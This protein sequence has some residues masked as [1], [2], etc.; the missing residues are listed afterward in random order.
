MLIDSHLH[1]VR[2]KG[3]PRN[4]PDPARA[5]YATFATPEELIHMMD[6]TGVDRGVL[7][8]EVNPE[9]SV[10]LSTV[11]EI[12]DICERYPDRFIPFCNIDPRAGSN[13]P[14]ADLSHPIR[15]YKNQGCRGVGEISANLPFD[16]PMM[17][18][19]FRHAQ[20]C[21]MPVVF[22]IAPR[23]GGC[24]GVIDDLHLPRLERVLKAFPELI[25][26]GHSQ[27]FWSEISADTTEAIRNGYPKGPVVPGG[28]VPR[29]LQ[30]C[31][32][33]YADISAGSG[34]NAL[35]RDPEFG[36]GFLETFQDRILFGTDCCSPAD[37]HTHAAYLREARETGKL[38]AGAFE[39]ITWRNADR[40]LSLSR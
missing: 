40:I 2:R 4:I 19:L 17:M 30:S 16:H 35:R 6:Q 21:E 22:H 5:A 11:E 14:D 24:Y 29:L 34:L 9:C 13:S 38:S 18:N 1:T 15:Y 25:F 36:Y 27:P 10:Q 37:N 33:L 12:L 8:P 28:A 39:K 20:A 23:A 7:L 31:P 3:L 32:N 26:I